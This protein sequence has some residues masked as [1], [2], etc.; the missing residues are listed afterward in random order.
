[1]NE[2]TE[3]AEQLSRLRVIIADDDPLVR[4]LVR[5]ALQLAGVVVIADAANGRE[6]VELARHYKPDFVLMD[7]VMPVM[8]GLEATKQI[9]ESVPETR[10]VMLT[11]SDDED[12]G[13]VGLRSGAVG[14]LTKDVPVEA[15]PRAL[16]GAQSGEAA[17]SR[18]LAMRLIQYMQARPE[19]GIGVRAVRSPLTPREWEVLDLLC[20]HLGTDEIAD[21][22]VLS[23]ETVRSH[24]KNILRK[25]GV[26]SR[27]EAVALASRLRGP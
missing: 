6:A 10:V 23:V 26:R 20:S 25:L 12:L 5:E 1:M 2:S 4:R 27:E 16:R 21:Q 17:I 24:I 11:G 22:L 13:I 9:S 14:Y 8:D 19:P 18:M 7:A 3:P 15:I